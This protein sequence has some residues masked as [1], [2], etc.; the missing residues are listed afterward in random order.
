MALFSR[1]VY[2]AMGLNKR[3]VGQKWLEM[4]PRE[5]RARAVSALC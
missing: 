2:L 1:H 4:F 5:L 3:T